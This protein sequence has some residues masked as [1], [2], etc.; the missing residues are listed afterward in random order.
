MEREKVVVPELVKPQPMA[1]VA[2]VPF[3]PLPQME[4]SKE[5]EEPV[6]EQTARN[7]LPDPKKMVIADY[8][9][10]PFGL[11]CTKFSRLPS[12]FRL[13]GGGLQKG[14]SGGFGKF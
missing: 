9:K 13:V 8:N 6:D 3:E 7:K 14:I 5:A 4:L 2:E 11:V 1:E 10:D 12:R